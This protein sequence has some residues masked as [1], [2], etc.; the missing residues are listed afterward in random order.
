MFRHVVQ[1]VRTELVVVANDVEH[2][3]GGCAREVV[4]GDLALPHLLAPLGGF[5]HAPREVVI[6]KRLCEKVGTLE[7]RR[8]LQDVR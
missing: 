1:L 4:E 8:T 3:Q 5:H 7:R 2:V 6:L